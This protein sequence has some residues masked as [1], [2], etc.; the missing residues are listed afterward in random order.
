MGYRQELVGQKVVAG[1]GVLDSGSHRVCG[2]C[3]HYWFCRLFL[4]TVETR[5]EQLYTN[6]LLA[7]FLAD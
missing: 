7:G 3:L 2:Q 5:H 6:E 1:P 4:L